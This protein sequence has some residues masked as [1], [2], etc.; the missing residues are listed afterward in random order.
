M[1][2]MN[3]L[4]SFIIETLRGG[5]SPSAAPC[6]R[7][8]TNTRKA[9]EG[10]RNLLRIASILSYS[11]PSSFR[12]NSCVRCRTLS[13]GTYPALLLRSAQQ[14][15]KPIHQN[16]RFPKTFDKPGSLRIQIPDQSQKAES[17][18]QGIVD[19]SKTAVRRIHHSDDVQIF[20][21]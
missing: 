1:F 8:Q 16:F 14:S 17:P 18:P 3:M 20:W 10:Y 13:P 6:C 12:R 11:F 9:W 7:H 21:D 15:L 4:L 2:L 19:H 5:Y